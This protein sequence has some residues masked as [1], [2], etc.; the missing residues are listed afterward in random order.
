MN[1]TNNACTRK[2]KKL[3]TFSLVMMGVGGL[4]GGGIFSVLGAITSFTG[5]YSYVSYVIM[6]LISL[7]TCYSY[8]KLT[9]RWR[10]SSGGEYHVIHNALDGNKN[11]GGRKEH[12][13][14]YGGFMSY[15]GHVCTSSLY[16]YTFSVYLLDLL[17]LEANLIALAIVIFIVLFT[18][19][20]LNLKGVQ[21]TAR[22][23]NLLVISKLFILSMFI[24]LGLSFA[25]GDTDTFL[26]NTGLTAEAAAHINIPGIAVGTSGVIVSYEGYQIIGNVCTDMKNPEKGIW[27]MRTAVI[28]AIIVYFLTAFTAISVLGTSGIAGSGHQDAEVAV[29]RAADQFMGVYGG[30][31]MSIGAIISTAS[32]LNVTVLGNSRVACEMAKRKHF[33]ELLGRINA[34]SNVPSNSIIFTS[35][36]SFLIALLTGGAMAV[37]GLTGLVFAQIFFLINF[38]NY[39]ARKKTKS[40]KIIPLGGMIAMVILFVL[41]LVEFLIEYE[42]YL[43]SLVFFVFTPFTSYFTPTRSGMVDARSSP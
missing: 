25:L 43:V 2:H 21:E 11:H 7:L 10:N 22:I 17:G 8:I 34:K 9:L 19:T 18:F 32:A 26:S 35:I 31:I 1:S 23:G 42:T 36:L 16:A 3:S 39:H 29:S 20:I 38:T 40:G 33:P 30:V 27:A 13:A 12:L 24:V 41:L 14:L 28:I 4:V 15:L 5:P 6:G 37:A